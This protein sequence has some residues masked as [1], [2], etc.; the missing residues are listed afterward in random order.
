MKKDILKV[1][2]DPILHFEAIARFQSLKIASDELGLSQPAV[3][4]SLS[5][6]ERNLGVQLCVR[7]RSAFELTEAGKRLF[8]ISKEIK[9]DLKKYEA[10]LTDERE[11]DGHLSIGVIDN[12]QN[13]QFE[14]TVKKT[15]HAFP[16]MKL[17]IQVHAATEIQ[18]LIMTGEV[19]IGFG[20]FNRKLEQLTY[21]NIGAETINFY[22]SEKHFLWNKKDIKVGQL[23][24]QMQTWVDII[25][26]NRSSL[27][28]EIFTPSNKKSVKISSYVNNLNAAVLI[29]RTGTSIVPIPAEYMQSRKLDF[30]YRSL[31]SV[32]T[33]YS[34][35]QEIALHKNFLT[36][37]AAAKFFLS[38]FPK[39]LHLK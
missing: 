17:S 21:R 9:A 32:F 34:L 19:D 37:S 22:I 33:P 36:A 14:E 20:I 35:N 23:K 24:D 13:S 25:S 29:L 11:F 38:Q 16:K 15:I 39:P 2:L 28:N 31:D 10:F 30:K 26:R 18:N 27:D 12:F 7:S 8:Q 5:K 1:G 6:L 3:T 4:Q